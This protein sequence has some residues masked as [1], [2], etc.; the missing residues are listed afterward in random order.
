MPTPFRFPAQYDQFPTAV[1]GTK[2][3]DGRVY[4]F[5]ILPNVRADSG[6]GAYALD[7]FN[8]L[9]APVIFGVK[10]VLSDDL[11]AAFRS[12]VEDVPPGRLVVRRTDGRDEDPAIYD[13]S[14]P[15][16]PRRLQ[17]FGSPTVVFEYVSLAE[18]E[19]GA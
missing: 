17:T 5:R 7:L 16:Q 2:T 3:L 4:R 12:T 9:G 6:R 15:D 1:T 11:L 18:I 10:L 13:R 14:V 8:V 19:A